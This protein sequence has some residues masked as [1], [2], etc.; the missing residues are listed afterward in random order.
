VP[1]VAALSNALRDTFTRRLSRTD[2]SISILFWSGVI[3][4]LAGLFTL[5]FGWKPIGLDGAMWFVAAGLANAAAQFL[6][7]EAFRLGA[8][9]LVAPFRYSGLLWAMLIGF[10]VWGEVPD[11]WM[12]AGG[13]IVV[14]AGLYMLGPPLR[15]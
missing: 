5:P 8:A 9:A 11:V 12:L 15:R 1:V 13:A 7:I 3:V 6:V 2:T 10:A 4:S 14:C